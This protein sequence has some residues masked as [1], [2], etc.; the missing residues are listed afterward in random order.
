MKSNSQKALA[1]LTVGSII[2][3]LSCNCTTDIVERSPCL[4]CDNS[5][6]VV[7]SVEKWFCFDF[8]FVC[9]FVPLPGRMPDKHKPLLYVHHRCSKGFE[10]SIR[11]C[12]KS[13]QW[14]EFDT[15]HP[16]W[17]G[18][19]LFCFLLWD[20]REPSTSLQIGQKG[21]CSDLVVRRLT[22]P[23]LCTHTHL[24]YIFL[25]RSSS[26]VTNCLPV[27]VWYQ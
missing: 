6:F 7:V 19:K 5:L 1:N 27:S 22:T 9:L 20:R 23:C 13:S 8:V 25:H 14:F 26:R 11:G 3:T 21:T 2:C 10:V 17:A 12:W 24:S 18:V 16:T 15:P 4:L